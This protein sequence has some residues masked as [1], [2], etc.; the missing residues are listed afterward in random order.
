MS[1]EQPAIG[2]EPAMWMPVEQP[3]CWWRRILEWL[4]AIV[5]FA[6]AVFVAFAAV[7]LSYLGIKFVW[8]LV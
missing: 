3:L 8:R 1:D 7:C 4:K 5:R 2:S 6:V